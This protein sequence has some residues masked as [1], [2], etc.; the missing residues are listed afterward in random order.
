MITGR[1]NEP[2]SSTAFLILR[3]TITSFFTTE[4]ES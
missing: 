3:A 2:K 1:I 4:L